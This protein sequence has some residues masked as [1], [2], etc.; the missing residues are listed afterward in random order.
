VGPAMFSML[1][2]PIGSYAATFAVIAAFTLV[3]TWL[4]AVRHP[5]RAR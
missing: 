2:G 5:D 1:V 3:G 4:V